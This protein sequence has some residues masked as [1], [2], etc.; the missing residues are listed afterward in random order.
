MKN[1]TPA[2]AFAE[3]RLIWSKDE[4]SA[5]KINRS[6]KRENSYTS[7]TRDLQPR[8]YRHKVDRGRSSV[9]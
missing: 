3:N 2:D 6:R 8:R 5:Q 9:Q 1:Q 7:P 4:D